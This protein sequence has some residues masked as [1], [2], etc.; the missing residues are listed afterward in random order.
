MDISMAYFIR[1]LQSEQFLLVNILKEV[2]KK[3]LNRKLSTESSLTQS[4]SH[5]FWTVRFISG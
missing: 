3:K 5:K 2:E 1:E 4:E